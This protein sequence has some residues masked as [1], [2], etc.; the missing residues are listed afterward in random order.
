MNK[1]QTSVANC[2]SKEMNNGVPTQR[3]KL[4]KDERGKLTKEERMG[5]W[6]EKA[7]E[8]RKSREVNVMALICMVLILGGRKLFAHEQESVQSETGSVVLMATLK[9]VK[10]EENE[11]DENERVKKLSQ[12]QYDAIAAATKKKAFALAALP[13]PP[14]ETI[15]PSMGLSAMNPSKLCSYIQDKITRI[16]AVTDFSTCFPPT[17]ISQGLIDSL[18]PLAM[19]ST[20]NTND[21]QKGN[22]ALWSKQLRQNFT[23]TA[24]SIVTI[25]N[26]NRAKFALTGI[27]LKKEGTT[28]TK[29]CDKPVF[30]LSGKHGAGNVYVSCKKDKKATKG[31]ICYFGKGE[32]DKA[33]WSYQLGTCRILIE[34]QSIGEELNFILVAINR[35]GEGFWPRPQSI[36][37]PGVI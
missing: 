32:Y 11:N 35:N 34:G 25:C 5:K 4:T 36:G 37:V 19:M 8:A 30:T 3:V 24:M 1:I 17:L 12:K 9:K 7:T 15:S 18:W 16:D 22:I 31:Y 10:E 26:G 13:V 6:F 14:Y 29:K 23:V 20:T 28:D 33:T 21:E 27:N 2:I